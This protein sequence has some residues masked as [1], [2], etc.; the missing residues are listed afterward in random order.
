MTKGIFSLLHDHHFWGPITLNIEG[1]KL[2]FF[3]LNRARFQAFLG[4]PVFNE[5][6]LNTGKL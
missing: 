4:H 2:L 6:F 1:K 5:T 3:K